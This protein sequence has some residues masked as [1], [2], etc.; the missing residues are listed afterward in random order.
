MSGTPVVT[1]VMPT[2]NRAQLLGDAVRSVLAQDAPPPYEFVVVDNNSKDDT[3]AVVEALIPASGGRLRYVFEGRQG[4]SHARNAGV[5]AARGEFVAFTDDDVR[6][7]PTWVAEIHRAFVQ[8]PWAEFVG[9]RVYARWPGPVPAWLTRDHWSPLALIDYGDEPFRVDLDRP[10][11]LVTANVAARRATFDRVGPFDPARQHARGAV[12]ASED[13]EWELRVLRS[14]GAGLYSPAIVLDAEVQPNR[15]GKAYHR[16]WH[17]DH[18]RSLAGLLAAGETFDARMLPVA[19]ATN[20]PMPLG[21]APWAYR[22]LAESIARSAVA[23]M[24][25][26]ESDAFLHEC[27][28]R[29]LVGHIVGV[30]ETQRPAGQLRAR[31]S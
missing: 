9:G 4:A 25:R 11:C 26:R 23:W 16:K 13:H 5:A 27:R 17:F 8:H 21:V 24:R 2:Y 14:G 7:S 19:Q 28:A 18:G 29:E 1:V 15:L 30:A 3:R 31:P 12:A 22:Q 6:T 10:V 20:R